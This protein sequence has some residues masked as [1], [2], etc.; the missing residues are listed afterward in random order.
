MDI[1]LLFFDKHTVSGNVLDARVHGPMGPRAQGP[2][3]PRAHSG[4]VVGFKVPRLSAKSSFLEFLSVSAGSGRSSGNGS[5]SYGSD[6]P[7][8]RAG[9]KDDGSY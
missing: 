7:Y 6:P 2:M 3:G 5:S 1:M 9:G 4:R 8:T